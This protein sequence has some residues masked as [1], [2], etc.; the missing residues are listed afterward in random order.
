[1]ETTT[2]I[3]FVFPFV[4]IANEKIHNSISM[5]LQKREKKCIARMYIL[6]CRQSKFTLTLFDFFRFV[7]THFVCNPLFCVLLTGN[8]PAVSER[9]HGVTHWQDATVLRGRV[10]QNRN[11]F[12]RPPWRS[13]R[14]NHHSVQ[15]DT[16]LR[17]P[18]QDKPHRPQRG[19]HLALSGV[20]EQ[21]G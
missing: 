11:D 3:I 13:D 21:S 5:I 20:V 2:N 1:M 4:P 14:W 9:H 17:G 7:L 19:G 15:P 6:Q 16:E 18:Q 10:H 12:D 8:A